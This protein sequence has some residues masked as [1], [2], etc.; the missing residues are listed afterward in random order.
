ME[1]PR[2]DGDTG[3]VSATGTPMLK[4]Y[5]SNG[6]VP[7]VHGSVS[8]DTRVS[9]VEDVTSGVAGYVFDVRRRTECCD[10]GP[11][12]VICMVSRARG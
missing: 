9:E 12:P 1:A 3:W 2:S 7:R 6:P 5:G 8:G 4:S 11:L 10:R